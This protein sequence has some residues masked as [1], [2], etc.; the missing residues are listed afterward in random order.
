MKQKYKSRLQAFLVIIF[1]LALI[2]VYGVAGS[3]DL[4]QLTAE[5]IFARGMIGVVFMAISVIT[6]KFIGKEEVT[7]MSKYIVGQ[8]YK[9]IIGDGKVHSYEVLEENNDIYGIRWD[10]GY[11]EWS[12]E[13]DMDYWAQAV[14]E[15]EKEERYK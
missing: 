13:L 15:K 1:L 7:H 2:Y 8:T 6:Y 4:N 14:N 11:E 5:Q 3:G 9:G 12:H 10:D